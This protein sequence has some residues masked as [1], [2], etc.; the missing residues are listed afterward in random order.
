MDNLLQIENGKAIKLVAIPCVSLESFGTS[1]AEF[2][3]NDGYIVQFFAFEQAGATK[4]LAVLRNEKLFV[5]SCQVDSRFPSLTGCRRRS[6]GSQ[7]R[8]AI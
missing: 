6:S 1:L 2:V 4:L 8:G 3:K 5:T 7:P